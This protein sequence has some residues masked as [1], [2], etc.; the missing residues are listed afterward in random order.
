MKWLICAALALGILS[1]QVQVQAQDQ[2]SE[3]PEADVD[4]AQLKAIAD[5][6]GCAKPAKPEAARGCAILAAFAGAGAPDQAILK[7]DSGLAGRRWIGWTI[8]ADPSPEPSYAYKA[9]SPFEI[10]IVVGARNSRNFHRKLYFSNGFGYSFIS[11]TNDRQAGMI[12][13]AARALQNGESIDDSAPARFAREVD[14]EFNPVQP[15]TGKSVFIR[16]GTM[17]RQRGDNLYVLEIG[18]NR[19]LEPIY[20][21]SQLRADRPVR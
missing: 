8:I 2:A 13:D 16:E 21:L 6:L 12:R 18:S 17:L 11:P 19:A 15:S 9:Q 3:T 5:A 4:S 7:A 10:M 14:L 1:L 20:Y